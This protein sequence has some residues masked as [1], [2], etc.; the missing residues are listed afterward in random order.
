[1]SMEHI[2]LSITLIGSKN[3]DLILSAPINAIEQLTKRNW[4]QCI[5]T[6]YIDSIGYYIIIMN[7]C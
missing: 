5:H 1:M 7:I 2:V 4:P 6:G 3:K